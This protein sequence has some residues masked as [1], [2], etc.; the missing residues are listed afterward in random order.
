MGTK[1]KVRKVTK[2]KVAKVAKVAKAATPDKK[3]SM[4]E[5]A[6]QTI[7][8]TPGL[9]TPELHA[10]AL[11]KYGK[12]NLTVNNCFGAF[13]STRRMEVV[14]SGAV[15]QTQL[16]K[17]VQGEGT[18]KPVKKLKKKTKNAAGKALPIAKTEGADKK[19][20]GTKP[21]VVVTTKSKKTKAKKKTK[22]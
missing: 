3:V 7:T 15:K 2:K 18:R 6:R 16:P 1:K 13:I 17:S 9:T 8:K 19:A 4:R 14:R 5:W 12:E 10:L 21:P 20:K 11:K 22:K